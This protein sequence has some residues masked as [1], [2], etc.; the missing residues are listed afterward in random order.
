MW[1]AYRLSILY[2]RPLEQGCGPLVAVIGRTPEN[3]DSAV[4]L[5]GEH[6][7]HEGVRPGLRP[8]REPLARPPEDFGVEAVGPADDEGRAADPLVPQTRQAGGESAGRQR[9]AVL[10]AGDQGVFGSK[11]GEQR[12]G[13]GRLAGFA[14]LDLDDLDGSKPY[15]A[16]GSG[17]A[18]GPVDREFRLGRSAEPPDAEQDDLEAQFAATRWPESTDQIFSIL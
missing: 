7:S 10:V 18:R 16:A 8:E 13:L 17:G 4:D 15:R 3:A 2:L 1:R 12:L 14:G 11:A 5:L 9:A 6:G